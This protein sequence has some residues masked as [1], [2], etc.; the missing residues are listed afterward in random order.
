MLGRFRALSDWLADHRNGVRLLGG[1]LFCAL[2]NVGAF[3]LAR[4]QDGQPL[5]HDVALASVALGAIWL[6]MTFVL[7]AE[8]GRPEER[9]ACCGRRLAQDGSGDVYQHD[10]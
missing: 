7:V 6:V 5:Q 2:A 10:A 9:C 8:S 1:W 4:L 3:P